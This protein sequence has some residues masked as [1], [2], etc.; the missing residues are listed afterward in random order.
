M[1]NIYYGMASRKKEKNCPK[2]S[3]CGNSCISRAKTCRVKEKNA[4]GIK[5]AEPKAKP[6]AA[7]GAGSKFSKQVKQQNAKPKLTLTKT[8]FETSKQAIALGK[9]ALTASQLKTLDEWSATTKKTRA[10]WDKHFRLEATRDGLK[11]KTGALAQELSKKM[12]RVWD[13]RA[14]AKRAVAQ[15]A[16]E[17]NNIVTQLR[18]D[19][20][21][22]SPMS[23]K[24]ARQAVGV[25]QVNN[26]S[27]VVAKEAMLADVVALVQMTNGAPLRG[28]LKTIGHTDRVGHA[29]WFTG[30]LNLG[31]DEKGEEYSRRKNILF[32]EIGHFVEYSDSNVSQV[33]TDWRSQR[34]S[35]KPTKLNHLLDTS[36]YK[37]TDLAV[38][39]AFVSPYVGRIYYFKP[40]ASEATEVVSVGLEHFRDV[41][42]MKD[43]YMK[44][45]EHFF[46]TLGIVKYLQNQ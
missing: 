35:G 43:L 6:K 41:D 3:P 1:Y 13:E 27:D 33:A 25:V 30:E 28:N 12:D 45:K 22:K 36:V 19:L 4:W 14:E 21:E 2:G 44:D 20:I 23:P 7:K 32:H 34:S 42:S 5:K 38:P 17:A 24:E 9:S 11:D 40:N 16:T 31:N 37:D 46:L 29:N 15:Q 26:F 18:R 8:K 10:L 39:D